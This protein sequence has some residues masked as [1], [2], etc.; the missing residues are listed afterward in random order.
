MLLCV[1]FNVLQ[2]VAVRVAA[3]VAVC[4]SV[5]QCANEFAKELKCACENRVEASVLCLFEAMVFCFF[6]V[7]V[8]L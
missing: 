4:C 8:C 7:C 1:F 6:C 3:C 5:I 2:R